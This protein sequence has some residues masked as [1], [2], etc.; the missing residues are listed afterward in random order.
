MQDLNYYKC[1]KKYIITVALSAVLIFLPA[2]SVLASEADAGVGSASYI[3]YFLLVVAVILLIA[4][5]LR[6]VKFKQIKNLLNIDSKKKDELTP[7]S[8]FYLKEPGFKAT[9]FKKM[10]ADLYKETQTAWMNKDMD[11]YENYF[12]KNYFEQIKSQIARMK[13]LKKTNYIKDIEVLDVELYG[14]KTVKGTELIRAGIRVKNIDFVVDDETMEVV[15]G[16]SNKMLLAEYAWD[17]KKIDDHERP[18][19]FDWEICNIETLSKS[20]VLKK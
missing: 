8:E 3:G 17:L 9:D 7:M 14:T 15:S 11:D 13:E 19:D 20:F 4:I 10:L 16:D 18:S 5:M 12:S 1:I 2:T 6:G